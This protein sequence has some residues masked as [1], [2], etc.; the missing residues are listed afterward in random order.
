LLITTG[1]G[2]TF[3]EISD[4]PLEP[5][6]QYRVFLSQT[7]GRLKVNAFCVS[8]V[9]QE[10]VAYRQGTNTRTETQDVFRQEIYRREAFQIERGLPFEAEFDLSVPTDAMHSFIAGHNQVNWTLVI[11]E[12]IVRWSNLHRAFTVIV[13]PA[14]GESDT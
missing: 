6:G 7:G 2:A 1:V 13:R 4:H 14:N 8:L 5:G 9:C 11:D 12:D 3:V 10:W